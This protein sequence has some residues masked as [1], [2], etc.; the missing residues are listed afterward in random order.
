MNNTTKMKNRLKPSYWTLYFAA[1]TTATFFA[2]A[3]AQSVTFTPQAGKTF[4]YGVEYRIIESNPNGEMGFFAQS[5]SDT[6][7][8]TQSMTRQR[9]RLR[10][11]ITAVAGG[12]WTAHYKTIPFDGT[13]SL[14][15][16]RSS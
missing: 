13:V 3:N 6:H 9:C 11:E 15:R 1:I 16:K 14:P 5:G 4:D 8:S 7:T 2:T 12:S 10:Y